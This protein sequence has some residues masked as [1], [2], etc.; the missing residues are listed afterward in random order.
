[1]MKKASDALGIAGQSIKSI[2]KMALQ[3]RCVAKGLRRG[4]H[5]NVN[6]RII[7]MG[8]GPSLAGDI[9]R[10][11]D[12]LAAGPAMSVNFAANT[13]EFT[14]LRPAYYVVIDPLFFADSGDPNMQRLW[15]NIAAVDWPMTLI[16]PRRDMRRLPKAVRQ[17]RCLTIAG[18][19]PVAVEGWR[20]LESAAYA[21][22]LGMPRPRNVLIPAIMAAVV[23][24]YKEIYLCGADHSWLKT[25]SVDE[26]NCVVSIQPHFYKDDERELKRQRKDYMKYPLHQ[27]LESF[28]I[29]FAAYH[30]MRRFA[31][32]KGICIFNATPG[33]YIDA[34][35]RREPWADS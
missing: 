10:H 9:E 4:V 32:I 25:I 23:M 13:P 2:I 3:S 27:I 14:R 1:M 35:P 28:S 12:V 26:G 34:F 7:I 33:S 20:W 19:N 31:H 22:G 21:S 30:R 15:D 8:N 29:A 11:A 17:N 16:V 24:G 5:G 6:R 18:V